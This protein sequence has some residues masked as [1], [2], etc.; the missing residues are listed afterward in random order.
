[1]TM[2]MMK[3]I[4]FFLF[5]LLINYVQIIYTKPEPDYLRYLQ[6]FGYSTPVESRRFASIQGG[7]SSGNEQLLSSAKSMPHL[8]EGIKKFQR[9]YKLP[10]CYFI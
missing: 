8:N 7:S 5:L 3:Q 4:V 6:Q 10:V 2:V 1:M 9:L